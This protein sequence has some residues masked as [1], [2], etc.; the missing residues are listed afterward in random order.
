MIIGVVAVL[1]LVAAIG[2]WAQ[3]LL[4]GRRVPD[5]PLA[6]AEELQ[7][8]EL[9]IPVRMLATLLLALRAGGG[10]P[11]LPGRRRRRGG[12]GGCRPRDGRGRGAADPDARDDVLGRPTCY[13][14]S[15]AGPDWR[16]GVDGPSR[17]TDS[18]A[19][20]IAQALQRAA[21]EERNNL[22]VSSILANNSR[23]IEMRIK[24]FAEARPTVPG[25][26]WVLLLATVATTIGGLAALGH[27]GVRRRVQL[28]V[29]SGT[30]AVIALTLV[31][32]HDL[33]RPF[34]GLV[35]IAPTAMLDVARRMSALPS[36]AAPPC[37][38]DGSPLAGLPQFVGTSDADVY[39]YGW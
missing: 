35:R 26:V 22:A 2:F 21:A 39:R 25:Q 3:H 34:D 20:A 16:A 7:V 37:A 13:A 15:V 24:R 10:V 32:M 36:A 30:T 12:G 23:R 33:V 38:A 14:R 19:D 17:V 11:V 6:R 31:I 4:F 18:A 28:A 8:S 27:P 29:L 5:D 1:A 9:V